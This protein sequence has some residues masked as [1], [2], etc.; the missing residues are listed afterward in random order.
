MWFLSSRKSMTMPEPEKRKP[1][2]TSKIP[3]LSRVKRQQRVETSE[4]NWWIMENMSTSSSRLSWKYLRD[5]SFK[6]KCHR[7]TEMK[8]LSRTCTSPTIQFSVTWQKTPKIPSCC[9]SA[10][11]LSVTSWHRFLD[12]MITS[13]K[14]LNKTT[15]SIIGK[16]SPLERNSI[17]PSPPPMW[18]KF[19]MRPVMFQF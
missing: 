16:S 9:K 6:L 1:L 12:S 18:I 8:K 13:R 19:E 2:K 15:N 4:L 5:W 7:S 17:S 3:M 14:K 10:E 11:I